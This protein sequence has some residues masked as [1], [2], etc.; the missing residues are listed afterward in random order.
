[1][2]RQMS[3]VGLTSE[4]HAF[5]EYNIN[6]M[7]TSGEFYLDLIKGLKNQSFEDQL[8]AGRKYMYDGD[9]ESAIPVLEDLCATLI[10]YK[11]G[12][13]DVFGRTNPDD[14]VKTGLYLIA[15]TFKNLITSLM[16]FEGGVYSIPELKE[17]INLNVLGAAQSYSKDEKLITPNDYRE[18]AQTVV[19]LLSP[20]GLE[21]QIISVEK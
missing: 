20:M 21:F 14:V 19:D 7:N 4:E 16:K 3:L 13:A 11:E 12:V 10:E 2:G 8:E 1:M 15:Y 6:G 5:S 9:Y 18:I 17:D